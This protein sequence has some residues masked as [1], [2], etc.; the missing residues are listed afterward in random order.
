[1]EWCNVGGI[2]LC[3]ARSGVRYGKGGTKKAGRRRG[4]E[5]N[6]SWRSTLCTVPTDGEKRLKNC[7]EGFEALKGNRQVCATTVGLSQRLFLTNKDDMDHILTA[8]R[9]I[10]ECSGEIVKKG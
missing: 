3:G 8:I 2:W 5:L 1:M 4:L 9:R 10:Q 6:R 7:R